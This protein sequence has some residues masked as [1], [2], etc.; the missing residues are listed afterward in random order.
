[1]IDPTVRTQR[2]LREAEDPDVAVVLLDVMLGFGSHPNPAEGLSKAIRQARERASSGGRSLA[3]V[4]YV[5]GTEADPQQ[6]SRQEALL[7]EEGVY[8]ASS[9]AEAARRAGAIIQSIGAAN[10]RE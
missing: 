8:L 7:A 1:M 3:V 9:N 5:C 6:R 4:A 10:A 2:L